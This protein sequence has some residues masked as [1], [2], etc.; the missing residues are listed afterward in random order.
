MHELGHATGLED[1]ASTSQEMNPERT[2][3]APFGYG[4]G[5]LAGLRKLG[6]NSGCLPVSSSVDIRD[7]ADH[8]GPTP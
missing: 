5:D 7:P 6:I 8:H 3:R 1:V 2:E 4:A